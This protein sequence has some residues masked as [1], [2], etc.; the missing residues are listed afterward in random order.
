M[1]RKSKVTCQNKIEYVTSTGSVSRFSFSKRDFYETGEPKAKIFNQ[2]THPE[3]K[4]LETSIC[5]MNG[6]K[7]NR[8]WYLGNNIRAGKTALAIVELNVKDIID[9]K[10]LCNSDPVEF[11]NA[12]GV[13]EQFEEHGVIVN[14]NIEKDLR[15]S[16]QQELVS[17]IKKIHKPS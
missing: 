9:T 2:E 7:N 11:T 5:G 8:L 10:L 17:K 12:V 13:N 14:W 1:L 6:L 16:E 3:T 4:L 15:I